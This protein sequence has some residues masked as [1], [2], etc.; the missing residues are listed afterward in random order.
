MR[1]PVYGEGNILER[2]G[3][4]PHGAGAGDTL[5]RRYSTHGN[6]TINYSAGQVRANN[7]VMVLN[8]GKLAAVCWQQAGTVNEHSEVTP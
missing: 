3:R 1:D 8:A 2:D 4:G 6:E 5:P 7:S